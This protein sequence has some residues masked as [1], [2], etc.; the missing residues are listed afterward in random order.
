MMLHELP[1]PAD[2]VLGRPEMADREADHVATGQFAVG[3]EH[4][5]RGVQGIQQIGVEPFERR[6]V[7]VGAGRPG[8][9]ADD[10]ER[11]RR[12]P[13]KIRVG[14][15]PAGEALGQTH[16]FAQPPPDP[17]GAEVAQHHPELQR[18]ESHE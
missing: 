8:A 9:E 3:K 14:V 11:Y 18:P 10:G 2:V 6:L 12:Q 16:V 7:P 1:R 5:A 17:L 15:D 4:F 13:F